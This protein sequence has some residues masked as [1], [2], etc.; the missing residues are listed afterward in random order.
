MFTYPKLDPSATSSTV[1]LLCIRTIC[2]VY[3]SIVLVCLA[4]AA[5]ILLAPTY[6]VSFNV[7]T[8]PPFIIHHTQ[9]T[10]IIILILIL[11]L[12]LNFPSPHPLSLAF[13][14][15]YRFNFASFSIRGPNLRPTYLHPSMHP[16]SLQLLPSTK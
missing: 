3:A 7:S 11:I 8:S 5:A 2:D 1:P 9:Y 16:S 10:T 15:S 6:S 4:E 14:H 12:I 13:R